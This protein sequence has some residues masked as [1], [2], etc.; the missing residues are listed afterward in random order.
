MVTWYVMSRGR[1]FLHMRINTWVCRS[2]GRDDKMSGNG[3]K[4]IS[5]KRPRLS[6]ERRG[7]VSLTLLLAVGVCTL[8]CNADFST[9]CSDPS[10]QPSSLLK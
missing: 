8:L 1:A 10:K 3:Q 2:R 4:L 9:D 7:N 6:M 5:D